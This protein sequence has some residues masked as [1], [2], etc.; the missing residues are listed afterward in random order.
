MTFKTSALA[1]AAAIALAAAA[2]SS[3]AAAAK[4]FKAGGEA[5]MVTEDLAKFMAN[6][7]LGNS[8]KGAGAT[9]SGKPTMNCKSAGLGTYCIANQKAC[10]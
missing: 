2:L 1:T 8:I 10:K 3:P 5:T 9:A 4:C 6:A 7:A